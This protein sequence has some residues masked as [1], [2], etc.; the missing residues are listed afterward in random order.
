MAVVNLS[1]I[2]STYVS[3]IQL[4]YTN[5]ILKTTSPHHEFVHNS[6]FILKVIDEFKQT[7]VK[8]W[9]INI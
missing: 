2:V 9:N 1:Y 7:K 8:D 4:L 5:E 3:S 6:S